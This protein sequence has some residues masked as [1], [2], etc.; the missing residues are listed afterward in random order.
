MQ[1]EKQTKQQQQKNTQ[2]EWKSRFLYFVSLTPWTAAP[3]SRF[4]N[5]NIIYTEK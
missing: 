5:K 3:F 1:T 4:Q 2:T